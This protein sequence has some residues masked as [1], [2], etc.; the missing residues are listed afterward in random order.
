[1]AVLMNRAP[2]SSIAPPS[3]DKRWRVVDATM[4]RHGYAPS[5]LIEALHAVQESFGFLDG[6]G[7]RYVAASLKVPLSRV[8]GVATFY[9][10][11]SMKPQGEHTCV[12]CTGTACYIKNSGT[13]LQAIQRELGISPG[14]TTPDGKL[15]LL[16]ARCLGTCGLAPAAVLDGEVVGR[17]LPA[18]LMTRLEQLAGSP[19]EARTV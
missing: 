13:L 7:L 12:V 6:P 1:M 4:R 19:Q 2:A 10:Y 17:L 3:D 14:E 18:D 8:F 5:A 15:S 11:F 9:H 16:T